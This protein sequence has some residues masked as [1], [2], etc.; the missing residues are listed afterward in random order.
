MG[1]LA[2]YFLSEDISLS[3][4]LIH[5][6]IL[7]IQELSPPI[8]IFP[9]QIFSLPRANARFLKQ[10]CHACRE[11]C[12]PVLEVLLFSPPITTPPIVLKPW[13]SIVDWH[14]HTINVRIFYVSWQVRYPR[15]QMINKNSDFS[16][17]KRLKTDSLSLNVGYFSL[18][19]TMFMFSTKTK[20]R[21]KQR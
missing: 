21:F 2:K 14:S 17:R 13:R 6:I 15:N 3:W 16:H 9:H 11:P 10:R 12:R 18:V 4:I 5:S 1:L 19:F 20:K 8:K 7:R